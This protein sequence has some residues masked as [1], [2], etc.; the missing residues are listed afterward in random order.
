MEERGGK[1]E[2]DWSGRWQEQQTASTARFD[3]GRPE[4]EARAIRRLTGQPNFLAPIISGHKSTAPS[5][6]LAARMSRGGRG[7]FGGGRGGFGGS[8]N[9]PPM[10][11]SFADIQSLSREPTA[12]YPV[13][14]LCPVG[15]GA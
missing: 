7:G 9:M 15:G 2:K 3:K 11:L 5:T 12:L 1:T 4:P 8:A 10:G 14:M 13:S 6:A